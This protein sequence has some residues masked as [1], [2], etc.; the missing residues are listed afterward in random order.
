MPHRRRSLVQATIVLI[1]II[2]SVRKGFLYALLINK[3]PTG[4]I[5][6]ISEISVLF[7]K[8][9]NLLINKS[10]INCL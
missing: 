8:L 3:I 2:H 6:D 7:R 4:S 9:K 1:T 10:L 5:R